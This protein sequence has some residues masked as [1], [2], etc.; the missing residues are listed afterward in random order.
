VLVQKV[1]VRLYV[2]TDGNAPTLCCVHTVDRWPHLDIEAPIGNS[3][4]TW[5]FT[6]F[7]TLNITLQVFF[8]FCVFRSHLQLPTNCLLH[9]TQNPAVC[10]YSTKLSTV[11]GKCPL[12][13]V[14][15]FFLSLSAIPCRML[16]NPS[17]RVYLRLLLVLA[18]L[19]D[20]TLWSE[21]HN[22]KIPNVHSQQSFTRSS[23]NSTLSSIQSYYSLRQYKSSWFSSGV[24]VVGFTS[25]CPATLFD[26][27]LI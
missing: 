17:T 12:L 4:H 10:H 21:S 13:C 5:N 20:L 7:K 23:Y 6:F 27:E 15:P 25:L 11:T 8:F 24:A 16:R 14:K 1:T 9:F 18:F 19:L 22:Y 2:N 3:S 26:Y